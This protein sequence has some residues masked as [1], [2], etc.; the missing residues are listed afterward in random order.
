[1]TSV[2]LPEPE[3]PGHADEASERER[4]VDVLEVVLGGAAH[5]ERLAAALAPRLRRRDDVL[6]GEVPPGQRVGVAHD[7]L[8]RARRD[9]VPAVLARAGP[10]VDEVVGGAHHR[11][12]VLDHEHGVA[13]VAEARERADEALIV[14]G[15]E[16]HRRLVADVEHAHQRRADLRRQPDALPLATRQRRRGAVE[17][18][19]VEADV[20]E[21]REAV[22]DLL[23][24]LARDLA[25]ARAER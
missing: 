8:R 21:E 5:D 11:L 24:D 12:V 9:D 14:D 22:G 7:L 1:M 2:D 19:V 13:E 4:H 18:E 25:L 23:Q 6:A 17:R 16:A 20:R 3:T 15:V 10:E